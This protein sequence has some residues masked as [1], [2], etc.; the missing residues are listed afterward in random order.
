MANIGIVTTW[1]E[2][3]AGYVSKAYKTAIEKRF[4]VFVYARGGE[5]YA[6]GDPEWDTPEV[7]WGPW[8]GRTHISLLHFNRWLQDNN[9]D[10]VLFNEQKILKPV[11]FAKDK[12]YKVGA[13]V[14]YYTK[15]T[16]KDFDIYD[17]LICN[18]QRHYSVFY[19]HPNVI[20]IPWGTDP[21]VFKPNNLN[22]FVSENCITFFHSAGMGGINLRKGTDF[23]V[24]AFKNVTAPAK[25]IIHSQTSLEKYGSDIVEIIQS[26]KRIEFIH[27][28]VSSPGLY[29]LGDVYIYPSRLEGIG[30]TICE[31]LSVGLPVI[32][33]DCA[34]MNEFVQ[35]NING[36]LIRV[37][38]QRYRNDNYYWPES[39][40]DV[41]NLTRLIEKYACDRQLVLQQKK[42]AR[43]SVENER[44]WLKNADQL[45]NFFATIATGLSEK[46]AVSIGEKV[47]WTMELISL[48]LRTAV[49]FKKIDFKRLC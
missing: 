29:H 1:F 43:E 6:E 25:L 8:F 14:D 44:T 24:K 34:P 15:E 17:F 21:K 13:Y 30:L 27:K 28:T 26:D 40:I 31:A 3:G 22:G 39:Y 35:D 18:T 46:K 23:L 47:Y 41:E 7:T 16:V 48:H 36:A 49:E 2:R 33:T 11:I 37:K 9:I 19:H 45:L 4:K 20:Y 5:K 42:A 10:I 38:E 12:G 32:T